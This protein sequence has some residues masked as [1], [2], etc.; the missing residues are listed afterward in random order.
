LPLLA[1]PCLSLH[2]P[3]S[4]ASVPSSLARVWTCLA[5]SPIPPPPTLPTRQPNS[6]FTSCS[7]CTV[8]K[9]VNLLA[10]PRAFAWHFLH[11]PCISSRS[12]CCTSTDCTSLWCT[13]PLSS[14]CDVP[15]WSL[16]LRHTPTNLRPTGRPTVRPTLALFPDHSVRGFWSS[17]IPSCAHSRPITLALLFASLFPPAHLQPRS[18]REPP[19]GQVFKPPTTATRANSS[20]SSLLSLTRPPASLAPPT[21]LPAVMSGQRHNKLP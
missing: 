7:G 9:A 15:S 1:S 12:I 2:L 20:S 5:N 8:P 14:V 4:Q 6:T 18:H 11:L 19:T 3:P 13:P 16:R 10:A 17:L 21:Q